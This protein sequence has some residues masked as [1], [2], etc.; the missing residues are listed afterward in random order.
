M[1]T[2]NEIIFCQIDNDSL[3]DICDVYII[4]ML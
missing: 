1:N 4:I 2:K 3:D